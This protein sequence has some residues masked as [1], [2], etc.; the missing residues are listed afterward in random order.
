M[1]I[2]KIVSVASALTIAA[3]A[4]AGLAVTASAAVG[5][6]TTNASADFTSDLGDFTVVSN[7]DTTPVELSNGWLAVGKGYG[8]VSI[9]DEELAGANDVVTV[10]F[11]VAYGKLSNRAFYYTIADS[12][13]TEIVNWNFT[14]YSGAINTNVLGNG[15]DL[16]AASEFYY[17]YNTPITGRA[18]SYVFTFDFANNTVTQATTNMYTGAKTTH[19]NPLPDGVENVKTLTIGS[20][21]D[22]NSDRRCVVDDILIQTTEGD[23]S[24]PSYTISYKVDGEDEAV[25]TVSGATAAGDAVTAVSSFV[26]SDGTKYIVDDPQTFTVA[27]SG[28]DFVQSC[29]VANNYTVTVKATGDIDETVNE[30]PV[31]E[32]ESVSYVFPQ[33]IVKG[34]TAY[35]ATVFSSTYYGGTESSVTENKAVEVTYTKKYENVVLY[36]ELDGSNDKNAGVRASNCGSYNNSAYTSAVLEPGSY[37]AVVRW[38][39]VGRGSTLTIGDT[40]LIDGTYL[41]DEETNPDGFRSGNWYTTTTA[42]FTIDEAASLVWNAGSA[43]TYDPIDT[44]LVYKTVS[45]TPAEVSDLETVKEVWTAGDGTYAEAFKFTVTPN[46]QTVTRVTVAVGNASQTNTVYLSDKGGA[47]FAIIASAADAESLPAASAFTVTLE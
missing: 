40:T 13:G 19:T 12:N 5:D 20:A 14:A 25:Y 2:K 26:T 3:S 41:Y 39:P 18:A 15:T 37:V 21:Y 42:E 11:K 29:R 10:S 32:G 43:N 6:V 33:Y 24:L 31:V 9:A 35:E 28:N 44:V 38:A 17:A 22:S 16:P 27:E 45:A 1:N 47:V 8:T 46:D 36:D 4:F 30:Y 34:G 7:N 23:S